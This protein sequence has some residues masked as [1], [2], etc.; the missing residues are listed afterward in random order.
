MDETPRRMTVV[1]YNP[2]LSGWRFQQM[3]SLMSVLDAISK[4]ASIAPPAAKLMAMAIIGVQHALPGANGADKKRAVVDIAAPILAGVQA[5]EPGAGEQIASHAGQVEDVVQSLFDVIQQTNPNV[6]KVHPDNTGTAV[7][8]AA[9]ATLP[10]AQGNQPTAAITS[11][12]TGTGT[13]TGSAAGSISDQLAQARQR[14]AELEAQQQ[15]GAGAAPQLGPGLHTT[16][17]Q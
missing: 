17:P 15:S 8:T 7:R 14:V 11:S 6:L 9:A 12:T 13:G 16:V 1:A 2:Q 3:A 10:Q 4:V 5:F